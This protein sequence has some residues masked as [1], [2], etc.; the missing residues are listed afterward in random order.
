MAEAVATPTI[1][2]PSDFTGRKEIVQGVLAISA[3]PATYVTGGIPCSFAGSDDIKSSAPPDTVDVKSQPAAGTSPSGYVYQFCPGTSQAN[4]LLAI[5]TG[6]AAQSPLTELTNG[7][8]IPAGVS[9]DTIYFK[10]QFPRL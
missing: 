2:E 4:G 7:A 6:A 8:S 9:G 3:S 10:A 5:L 1:T